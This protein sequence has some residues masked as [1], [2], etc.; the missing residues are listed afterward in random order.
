MKEKGTDKYENAYIQAVAIDCEKARTPTFYFEN[1]LQTDGVTKRA[2]VSK[3]SV[4][5][6]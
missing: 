3:N 2:T 5:L 1:V 4:S 6:V